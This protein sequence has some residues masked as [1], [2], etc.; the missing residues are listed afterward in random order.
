MIQSV[1]YDIA[2]YKHE[3]F[4]IRRLESDI[5]NK[6]LQLITVKTKPNLDYF[7]IQILVL[8][9]LNSCGDN[10]ACISSWQCKL[11]GYSKDSD[12]FF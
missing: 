7:L 8:H 6:Y 4:I 2:E 12:L 9:R 10:F 5:S 1:R 3:V 11:V